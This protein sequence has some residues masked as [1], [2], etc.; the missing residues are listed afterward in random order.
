M[1]RGLFEVRTNLSHGR[2]ARV[3]FCVHEEEMVLL[4]G[5]MKKG[6]KTPQ[7]DMDLALE[8]KKKFTSGGKS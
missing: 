3:L 6:Q 8:R 1:G 5:F 2:I 7:A 4:H